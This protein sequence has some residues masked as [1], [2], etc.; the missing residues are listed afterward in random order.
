MTLTVGS[1]VM[2]FEEM[3]QSEEIRIIGASPKR[4]GGKTNDSRKFGGNSKTGRCRV[5]TGS[6]LG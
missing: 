6:L 3:D 4:P 2:F 5:K 1:K